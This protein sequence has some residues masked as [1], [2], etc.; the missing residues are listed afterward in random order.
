MARHLGRQL[1][2][3][4]FDVCVHTRFERTRRTAELALDGRAVP[5]IEEPGLDDVDVG[6]LEGDTIAAYHAWKD[7]HTRADRF[8]GGESLDETARRYVTALRRVL[9]LPHD[10]VLV[11]C[12]ELPIRYAL[13]ALVGSDDPDGPFRAIPN[14][15]PFLFD[16]PML[17]A[18]VDRI[19]Q[20]AD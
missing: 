16:A 1:A 12:H 9:G 3:T 14:A 15:T 6:E 18:A 2:G 13:N 4:T 17:A 7:V 5:L 11:I 19:E 20:L 10:W 8:P